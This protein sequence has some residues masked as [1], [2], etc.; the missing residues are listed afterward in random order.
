MTEPKGQYDISSAVSGEDLNGMIARAFVNGAGYFRRR[1][2]AIWMI[3]LT[4]ITHRY[5]AG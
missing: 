5:M 1:F 4:W 3:W 2:S